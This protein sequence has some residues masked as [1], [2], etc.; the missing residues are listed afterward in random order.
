MKWRLL[1]TIVLWSLVFAV[2]YL[3]NTTVAL[4]VLAALSALAQYESQTLLEKSGYRPWKIVPLL[5]GV[6]LVLGAG[7]SPARGNLGWVLVW[8]CLALGLLSLAGKPANLAR[9]LGSTFAVAYVP[10]LM[11]YFALI[12]RDFKD[13]CTNG[14]GLGLIIWVIAV[15]K[16]TDVGAFVLGS[17]IGRAKLAPTI[18]PGKT[19]EGVFGGLVLAAVVGGFGAQL[20][21]S[22]LPIWLTPQLGAMIALPLAAAAILSDLAESALKRCAGV[23]DSGRCIPGIGGALDLIDSLLLAAPVAYYFFE[24]ISRSQLTLK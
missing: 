13:A 12:L 21:P 24:Y 7:L 10:D 22:Y 4:V 2:L 23:K 9:L 5:L 1:S 3:G 11:K 19:W 20:A 8:F 17:A 6:I 15:A 18:S 14:D 16:F